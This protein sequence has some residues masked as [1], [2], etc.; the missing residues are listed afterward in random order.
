MN[1]VILNAAGDVGS[2]MVAEAL[3][4][5]HHVT[6]AV[7]SRRSLQALPEMVAGRIIGVLKSPLLLREIIAGD[8]VVISVFARHWAR[9][10]N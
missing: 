1:I 6:A 9:R 2:R 8:D 7:R 10:R 4:R 5:G 3:K